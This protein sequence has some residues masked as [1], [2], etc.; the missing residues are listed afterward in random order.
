MDIKKLAAE[1][2]DL[3]VRHRSHFHRFPE[4]PSMEFETVRY[5]LAE[6]ERC[7]IECVEVP[8]GGVLGFIIGTK[9]SKGKTV[10]LRADCDA[11]PID[12]PEMNLLRKRTVRSENPGVMHACGH[13]VHTA[14]L[15][16]AGKILNEN[17]DKIAGTVMLCF[18]R[19]EEG[20]G[21]IRWLLEHFEDENIRYDSAFGVHVDQKL[22]TGAI[23]IIDGSVSSVSM[24]IHIKATG[25]SG[26]GSRPDLSINPIDCM[27]A[28]INGLH[29]ARTRLVSPFEQFSFSICTFHAGTR[30][31][32]IPDT[33]EISG[34]VRAY[35]MEGAILPFRDAMLNISSACA[36]QYGCEVDV[37]FTKKV[38]HPLINNPQCSEIARS[39]I[40]K[41]YGEE[42]LRPSKPG[43]GSESFP[44]YNHFAP[45]VYARLGITNPEVGSG[46]EPH[47]QFFDIDE[48]CMKIGIA[49]HIAYALDF[50][51]SDEVI[52][53]KAPTVSV[54]K[55]FEKG[56]FN[57]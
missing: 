10:L 53:F 11:L 35:S 43:M 38:S 30:R 22:P 40:K 2:F 32:I 13:D 42:V 41:V 36:Q 16:V 14:M 4:L 6:L 19:G 23:S 31:N 18:E 37:D 55:M 7:G 33:A 47:N 25:R 45:I 20:G 3:V 44:L 34:S 5:I 50:L 21:N 57:I 29:G 39:A 24:P 8:D 17:K 15:L 28:I 48:E 27:V 12:E 46:A 51:E 49:A 54:K 52:D 9:A 1:N 56:S 26:H